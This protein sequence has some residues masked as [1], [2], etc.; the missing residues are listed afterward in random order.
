M[1]ALTLTLTLTPWLMTLCLFG[2]CGPAVAVVAPSGGAGGALLG[3]SHAGGTPS[4]GGGGDTWGGAGGLPTG[5]V[6]ELDGYRICGGPLDCPC[7]HDCSNVIEM[8][9]T[10]GPIGLCMTPELVAYL[11]S[12]PGAFGEPVRDGDVRVEV[13]PGWGYWGRPAAFGWLYLL[14]GYADLARYADYGA[15][16]GTP[17]PEPTTCPTELTALPVCGGQCGLDCGDVGGPDY[18]CSGRS[19]LHPYGVCVRINWYPHECSP[20]EPCQDP[21]RSCFSFT[22]DG[23]NQTLADEHGFCMLHDDCEGLAAVLPGGGT[24]YPPP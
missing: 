8:P 2:G 16:D 18:V 19:K 23:E 5:P 12:H 3:G 21:E 13:F 24:C 11:D 22:V 7:E 10:E 9:A 15:F 6:C 17:L 14:N 20:A 4:S 1:R